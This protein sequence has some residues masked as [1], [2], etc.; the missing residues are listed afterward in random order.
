MNHHWPHEKP[1]NVYPLTGQRNGVGKYLRVCVG[2]SAAMCR[3]QPQRKTVHDLLTS[4]RMRKTAPMTTKLCVRLYI[5]KT[6][7]G[8]ASRG[9]GPLPRCP[10]SIRKMKPKLSRSGSAPDRPSSHF[11]GLRKYQYSTTAQR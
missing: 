8:M 11:L 4:H 3:S 1:L 7:P 2:I 9:G 6:K 5:V 10:N